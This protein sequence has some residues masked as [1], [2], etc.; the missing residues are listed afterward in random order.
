MSVCWRTLPTGVMSVDKARLYAGWAAPHLDRH[1]APTM[2]GAAAP[3]CLAG[4]AWMYSQLANHAGYY[5]ARKW[6]YDAAL[7]DLL[8]RERVLEIGCGSGNFITLAKA[9]AGLSIEGLEQNADAISEAVRRGLCVREATAEDAAKQSPGR[10][11][12]ICSFQVFEHV[13]KPRELL[14]ACCM[15]LRPGGLLILGAPNQDSYIRYLVNPLDMPP[16][17]MTRWTREPLHRLQTHF[18]LK[19][20][21][22]ACE[23][24]TDNQIEMYVD[25]YANMLRR[26]DLGFLIRPRIY[27]RTIRLIRYLRLGK[28]LR[29]QNIYACYVRN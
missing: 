28:F 14:D 13:S 19:L 16:H 21:R 1:V 6:E 18:P 4:S 9:K 7:D 26:R 3:P 2:L 20:V 15:L 10:Y 17:H 8:G 25:T 27:S 11:D 5:I 24:L 23:P 29:G 22:T 12:A